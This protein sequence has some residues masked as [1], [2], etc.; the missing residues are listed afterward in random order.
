[1]IAK[2]V[3][4]YRPAGLLRYL[5]GPGKFEEHK[6]PRVVASWDS[7]P[8]LHQPAKLMAVV[9]DG[10]VVESG[11]FDFDLGPLTD[12]MQDLAAR[13][14]LPSRSPPAITPEWTE[15]LQSGRRLPPEAPSWLSYYKYDPK[16]KAVVLRDGYVWHC[17][18]RLHPTDPIL[19]DQQWEMIAERLMGA[20]GIAQKEARWIA[21]RHGDDHIHL[22]ATLVSEHTGKQIHPYRD[23]VRLRAECRALERELG[24][25]ET[26]GIDKT[27]L[28]V[29]TRREKGKAERLGRQVTARE[30]LRRLVSHAAAATST[31]EQFLRDLRADGLDPRP[32][33]DAD[34]DIVGYTVALPGDVTAAGT[35]VRYSGT[36]L[37][38][39]LTWPKLLA[40]WDSTPLS[41]AVQTSLDGRV[42]PVDRHD[43]ITNATMAVEQ[44]IEQVRAGHDVDGI[45]HATGEVM[46]V[47]TRGS[48][49][50]LPG[51][52]A[53]IAERVDRAARTPHLVLPDR[54]G[55]VARDLRHAA[56]RIAA[57]G[58]LSGRGQERFASVALAIALAGLLAEIAAWQRQRGRVHQAAAA[59]RAAADLPATAQPG[60]DSRRP[61]A[62]RPSAPPATP[63]GAHRDRPARHPSPTVS[64]DRHR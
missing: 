41:A 15:Q 37:G 3:R 50:R 57:I 36:A 24:L 4:G 23:F 20:T 18:V 38:S 30:E 31:G 35:P 25:Y 39:D 22:M 63:G 5:F 53:A 21:I 62:A 34:G 7:A 16:R 59:S 8:W 40:R 49:G 48:E 29:P 64:P 58:A 13:A 54:H 17:P 28:A 44:A 42:S 55:A 9:M 43:A 12:T 46:S 14:G 27:A 10:E 47:L 60:R 26:A 6:N 45:A 33:R 51:P 19:S 11:E 2:V 1:M 56:R 52:L 61:R 32:I